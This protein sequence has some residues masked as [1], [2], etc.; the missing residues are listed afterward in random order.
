MANEGVANVSKQTIFIEP[1]DVWMF[2]DNK[3]FDA[4]QNFTARSQ[5]PPNPQVI[6][7]VVRTYSYHNNHTIGTSSDMGGLTVEGP[8]VA[9]YENGKYNRYFTAPLDLLYDPAEKFF[10]QMM[11]LP[12]VDFE[13]N[14][15]ANLR[16]LSIHHEDESNFSLKEIDGWL[17]ETQFM[18]YLKGELDTGTVLKAT[19]PSEAHLYDD[20]NRTGLQLDYTRRANK[21]SML[22]NAQFIRLEAG[23]GLMVTADYKQAIFE[24]SGTIG[25]GGE[26]R[27]G[28]YQQVAEPA[29]LITQ[30]TGNLKVILL[31]PAYFSDGWQP[32]NG[33]WS[34][35]VGAGKLVSVALGK[36]QAISGWDIA[37]NRPK[38]LRH[39]VPAGSVF[40]FENAEWQ[41][42]AFS[43]SANGS[44]YHQM[45]FGTVA[46]SSW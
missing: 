29:S 4:Q 19:H 42:N 1:N 40:Y 20:E 5:F 27:F 15:P 41:N 24:K 35:F 6:Q 10:S 21:E 44:P 26:S 22:Y 23:F 3:P 46:T 13:S 34:P 25:I 11:V 45:G 33:D 39:F 12:K 14:M 16:P 43:E 38:P 32:Q 9:K 30:T 36:A 31:T 7:G 17:S 37:N 18:A 8:F 2:R 28:H